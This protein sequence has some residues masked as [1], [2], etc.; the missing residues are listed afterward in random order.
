[1]LLDYES[2]RCA[3]ALTALNPTLRAIVADWDLERHPSELL[4]YFSDLSVFVHQRRTFIRILAEHLL[5]TK[6]EIFRA[7]TEFRNTLGHVHEKLLFRT[8]IST[9]AIYVSV[10]Y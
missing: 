1:M 5:A 7:V 8:A 10:D 9:G 6:D 3:H 4:D 2:D